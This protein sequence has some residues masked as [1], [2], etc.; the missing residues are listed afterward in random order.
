LVLKLT[1][2]GL[3]TLIAVNDIG[4]PG[5][6]HAE[7]IYCARAHL[8]ESGRDLKSEVGPAGRLSQ[9]AIRRR[10]FCPST[11]P[12]SG[13]CCLVQGSLAWLL[14]SASILSARVARALCPHPVTPPY[15]SE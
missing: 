9:L 14:S 8:R 11:E 1:S 5:S 3:A 7:L 10:R 2:D 6:D 13:T 4:D 12:S 15:S